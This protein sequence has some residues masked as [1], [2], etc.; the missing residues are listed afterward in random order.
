MLLSSR[1]GGSYVGS[2]EEG[3]EQEEKEKEDVDS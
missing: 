3:E 2:H 1:A